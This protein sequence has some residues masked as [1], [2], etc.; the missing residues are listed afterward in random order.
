[1]Q[2]EERN[3]ERLAKKQTFKGSERIKE[4]YP[5]AFIWR[6]VW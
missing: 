4:K 2:T 1:V 6:K 5:E 3:D